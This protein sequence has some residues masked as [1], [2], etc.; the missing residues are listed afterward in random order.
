V[1]TPYRRILYQPFA[2][3]GFGSI[4]AGAGGPRYH[5]LRRGSRSKQ[6]HKRAPAT[7]PTT[8]TNRLS[9]PNLQIGAEARLRY[10]VLRRESRS[11]QHQR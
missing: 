4:L 5:V 7:P 11:K 8:L 10:R 9:E 2:T 3:G 1:T 6:R